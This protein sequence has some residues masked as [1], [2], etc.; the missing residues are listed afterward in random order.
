MLYTKF[1]FSKLHDILL[2]TFFRQNYSKPC[3]TEF[4]FN[5]FVGL[6]LYQREIATQVFASELY[7][8]LTNQQTTDLSD[9]L[10]SRLPPVAFF[11]IEYSVEVFHSHINN[12]QEHGA[13]F[14]NLETL[15]FHCIINFM[16]KWLVSSSPRINITFLQR[17]FF[18]DFLSATYWKSFSRIASFKNKLLEIITRKVFI[19]NLYSPEMPTVGVEFN[20]VRRLTG[21]HRRCS[22]K[23]DALKNFSKFTE[24]HPCCHRKAPKLVAF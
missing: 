22:V 2:Y 5:K 8:I 11:I 20:M 16:F 4:L 17:R 13:K 1:H 12:N 10:L 9:L 3:V 18:M 14:L 6:Q 23:K 15:W 19:V 21:S 7:E 24:K